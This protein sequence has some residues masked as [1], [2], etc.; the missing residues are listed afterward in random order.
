M[1]SSLTRLPRF[2]C[3]HMYGTL[4]LIPSQDQ[5][6]GIRVTTSIS[7]LGTVPHC[8]VAVVHT[9][10]TMVHFAKKF[11]YLFFVAFLSSDGRRAAYP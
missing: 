10:W 11:P 1:T 3:L 2:R 7:V 4:L 9:W 6:S 8:V 5:T